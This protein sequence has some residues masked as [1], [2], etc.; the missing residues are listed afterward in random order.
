M[1]IGVEGGRGEEGHC[2]EGYVGEI[3][4]LLL[5]LLLLLGCA[6]VGLSLRLSVGVVGIWIGGIVVVGGGRGV[7]GGRT[8][9]ATA[10]ATREVGEVEIG[11]VE[12]AGVGFDGEVFVP[13]VLGG[14]VL[15]RDIYLGEEKEMVAGEK[16]LPSLYRP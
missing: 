3:F 7:E 10:A 1:R 2:A 14:V 5:L 11:N 8:T 13:F 4:W 16:N 9:A 15:A 6:V 12:V